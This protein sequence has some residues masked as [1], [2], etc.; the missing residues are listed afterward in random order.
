M[1]A[2]EPPRNLGLNEIVDAI[3]SEL[4][5]VLG[6]DLILPKAETRTLVRFDGQAVVQVPQADWEEAENSVRVEAIT[7]AGKVPREPSGGNPIS[8]ENALR[9]EMVLLVA[10]LTALKNRQERL[11]KQ[12]S[13]EAEYAQSLDDQLA[14]LES[15]LE[16]P[17]APWVGAGFISGIQGMRKAL[18][19]QI[20]FRPKGGQQTDHVKIACAIGAFHLMLK[21]SRRQNKGTDGS[22]FPTITALLYEAAGG[23]REANVKRA[24]DAVLRSRLFTRVSG[25]AAMDGA[26]SVTV[27]GTSRHRD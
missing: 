19:L 3:L 12:R 15:M 6:R 27:A 1:V 9:A 11:R 5:G 17:L 20:E 25:K 13:A 2:P 26:A 23:E 7:S 16:H 22:P 10:R 24:C 4:G 14:K 18:Q 8:P 21:Y